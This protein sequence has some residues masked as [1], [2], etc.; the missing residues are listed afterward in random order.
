[1]SPLFFVQILLV[2]AVVAIA[3][4]K[5]YEETKYKNLKLPTLYSF[6]D[7]DECFFNVT[8]SLPSTYCMVYAEVQ[9][10]NSSELW[11]KITLHNEY[12][13]NY[14]RNKLFFG[15]CLNKC[16]RFLRS[17]ADNE[18]HNKGG[19]LDK[20]VVE[21]FQTVHKRPLDIE[22]RA[23]H[24]SMIQRCL[25][26]EFEKEYDLKLETFIEYCERGPEAKPIEE[27][28]ATSVFNN[29]VKG[30]LLLVFCS[31]VYD[32]FLKSQQMDK[33]HT[34]DFYKTNYTD[35]AS[36][37]LTSFSLA[38]NYY[39][40]T[41]PARGTIG[42][43]FSFLDGLRSNCLLIV[44]M[45]H[46]FY[47]EFLHIKNPEYF[48]NIGKTN[49]GLSA[50]NGTTIIEI[51]MVMSGLLLYLKFHKSSSVTPHSTWGQCLRQ[52]AL[53]VVGRFL[54]YLPSVALL[55]L[56]NASVLST[57]TDGPF[58]RHISEPS[59]ILSRENW[60]HNIFMIN[61]FTMKYSSSLHTWYIAAD[62]QLF[63]FYTLV[64]TITSKYPQYKKRILVTLSIL[65][66]LI[67]TMISYL[68]KL[69]ALLVVKPENLRYGYFY[70][71]KLFKY[72]YTPFYNNLGGYIFGIWCGDL[73]TNYLSKPEIQRKI[74]G[75][76]KYE[77]TFW[78]I[79]PIAAG[80]TLAG[81]RM[82]FQQPS[83][84]TALFSGLNRNLWIVFVCGIPVLGMTCKA[85]KI[86]YEFCCLPLFRVLG[87]LSF[88]V[89]LWHGIILQIINGYQRQPHYVTDMYY[90]GQGMTMFMLSLI[91]AFFACLL[92]E[93]P[94]GQ[95]LDVL[96]VKLRAKPEDPRNSKKSN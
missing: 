80:I 37:I 7:Y 67:P 25:N 65:A 42:N 48:E 68:L 57:L 14:A 40:L 61:N 50:L 72:L 45:G 39:R 41:Q 56:F 74:R 60:W 69:E 96:I 53:I 92:V 84:W 47:L 4:G 34:N 73:Y 6:D 91:T 77:I 19:S 27:D 43:E 17:E 18:T 10:D 1:M 33:N 30:I 16:M 24:S 35:A 15:V 8:P 22:M 11:Q 52:L 66:V 89:Y 3:Q 63:A 87:R 13:F 20:E 28:M 64:L 75:V 44:L 59:R 86:A 29:T 78:L 49:V 51:F 58:W 82:I 90:T 38:R 83:V 12:K 88:Q 85:G 9:P 76:L 21:F 81:T 2:S 46:N 70:N 79:F 62:I 32:Y 71:D 54:R 94:F 95:I 23:N 26:E 5:V 93:Y 31:S 55:T 36:A